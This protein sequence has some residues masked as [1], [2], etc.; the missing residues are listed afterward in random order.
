M[1][2]AVEIDGDVDVPPSERLAPL[3]AAK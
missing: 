3:P 1:Q 2:I